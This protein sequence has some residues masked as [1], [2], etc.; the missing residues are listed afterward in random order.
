VV[1]QEAENLSVLLALV[2]HPEIESQYGIV[3]DDGPDPRG[4][5]IAVLY[6]LDR[7]VLLGYQLKQGCTDLIVG[8]GPDGNGDIQAPVNSL[9]HDR[10]G[11][12]VPD[13]NRLFS[14]PPLVVK[15]RVTGGKLETDLTVIANHW[16]SKIQDTDENQYT[17]PRRILQAQFVGTLV[18]NEFSRADSDYIIVAGDLND[19]PDSEPISILKSTGLKDMTQDI[20]RSARYSMIYRGVSQVLDYVLEMPTIHYGGT[21]VEMLHINADFPAVFGM[22]DGIVFRSSD[23]D[24]MWVYIIPY[25]RYIYFP[26]ILQTQQD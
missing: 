5:D 8:L 2:N 25:D 10:S 4:L 3:W 12:G 6:R 9:T 16:K 23:H 15:L 1:V 20:D 14:R 7:A 13:G 22:V 19:V 21:Q 17:L 18:Q 24:P 11:D 26:Q